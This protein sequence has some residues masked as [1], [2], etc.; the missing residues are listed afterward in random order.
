MH[1]Q[2]AIH[3]LDTNEPVHSKIQG[4]PQ[5]G[6]MLLHRRQQQRSLLSTTLLVWSPEWICLVLGA[7][8]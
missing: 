3:V 8:W 1:G 4:L 5:N 7:L 6:Y 2:T